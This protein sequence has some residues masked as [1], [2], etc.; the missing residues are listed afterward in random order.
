MFTESAKVVKLRQFPQWPCENVFSAASGLCF[1]GGAGCRGGSVF[2]MV[3]CIGFGGGGRGGIEPI[4]LLPY[5]PLPSSDTIPSPL[6]LF[7]SAC[8]CP[9]PSHLYCGIG[10]CRRPCRLPFPC[11]GVSC[12]RPVP[13]G[14]AAHVPF[15]RKDGPHGRKRRGRVAAARDLRLGRS[16]AA[17]QAVPQRGFFI[18]LSL[19]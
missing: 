3:D 14:A 18:Y 7:L 12:R 11:R 16:T 13:L 2:F 5:P 4:P 6:F 10:L 1:G 15:G 17:R 8:W 9:T 19:G